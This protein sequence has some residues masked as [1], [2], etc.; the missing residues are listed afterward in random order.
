MLHHWKA[1]AALLAV[2]LTLAASASASAEIL[3]FYPNPELPG[4]RATLSFA[5]G[6]GTVR[7]A[8]TL[9]GSLIEPQITARTGATIARDS[10]VAVGTCENGSG[11]TVLVLPWTI[12]YEGFTGTLPNVTS[13]KLLIHEFSVK[14]TSFAGAPECLF[15][16]NVE[17]S[18]PDRGSDPFEAERFRLSGTLRR[19]SGALCPETATLSSEGIWEA[20]WNF[21]FGESLKMQSVPAWTTA[22]RTRG[23]FEGLAVSITALQ[24]VTVTTIGLEQTGTGWVLRLPENCVRSYTP[25]ELRQT[26]TARVEGTSATRSNNLLLREAGG[27][28]GKVKLQL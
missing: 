2:A 16:G 9:T 11:M 5:S 8:V 19:V 3:E 15:A 14:F 25:G 21:F 4:Q 18:V 12:T 22:A 24:A 7:C 1:S 28:V 17:Q 10:R 13:I 23:V 26:C 20:I 27:V 6:L